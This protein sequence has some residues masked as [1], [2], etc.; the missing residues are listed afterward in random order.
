MSGLVVQG[1]LG[2]K[3]VTD[4]IREIAQKQE[5]G[6]LRL[7]RGKTI[8]AIFFDNGEP[9]FAISNLTGEQL[10]HLLI[11]Q[12]LVSPEQIEAAKVR[13]GKVPRLAGV[14]VEMGVLSAEAMRKAVRQQVMEIILSLFEWTQGDYQ[15]DE[16]I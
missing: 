10:D 15:L 3:L 5:S 11:N 13:D 6:L 2:A 16:R 9:K 8:K 4:L 14:L 12:S 7:T 1:Q